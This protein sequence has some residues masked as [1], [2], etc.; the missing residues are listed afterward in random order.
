MQT[1]FI[2]TLYPGPYS[3][4]YD[5]V[6]VFKV[7]LMQTN[8]GATSWSLRWKE[9]EVHLFS[10]SNSPGEKEFNWH[11]KHNCGSHCRFCP[12]LIGQQE[13]NKYTIMGAILKEDAFC[14]G[15][16][17][18]GTKWLIFIII[19]KKTHNWLLWL[20]SGGMKTLTA[21]QSGHWFH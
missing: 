20:K 5:P 3:S 7:A 17:P 12:S 16:Q 19:L 2:Y 6:T 1:L 8:S 18:F 14:A 11:R 15:S 9:V 13:N 10:G 4:S 21:F